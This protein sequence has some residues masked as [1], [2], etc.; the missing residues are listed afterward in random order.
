VQ[1]GDELAAGDPHEEEG[2]TDLKNFK[3]IYYE[4]ETERYTCP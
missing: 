1:I 2:V 3:G 4:Q